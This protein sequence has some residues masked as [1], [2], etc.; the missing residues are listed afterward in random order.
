MG[1]DAYPRRTGSTVIEVNDGVVDDTAV[2]GSGQGDAMEVIRDDHIVLHHPVNEHPVKTPDALQ[3]SSMVLP[4]VL[5]ID[6]RVASEYDASNSA[7]ADASLLATRP[8]IETLV[9]IAGDVVTILD[10]V[11]L[12]RRGVSE[13]AHAVTREVLDDVPGDHGINRRHGDAEIHVAKCA[14]ADRHVP[15]VHLDP[16]ARKR[17]P[18]FSGPA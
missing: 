7:S 16:I 10:G 1:A 12:K 8:R 15:A 4:R 9:V 11:V 17:I 5:V 6:D 2:A 3:G 14:V 13:A 18:I